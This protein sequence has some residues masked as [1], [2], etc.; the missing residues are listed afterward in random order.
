MT[1]AEGAAA[2]GAKLKV[3]GCPCPFRVAAEDAIT[4]DAAVL[5]VSRT[6]V[7]GAL[8]HEVCAIG[9]TPPPP[10]PPAVAVTS[11]TP[12]PA[13]LGGF[14]CSCCRM[15]MEASSERGPPSITPLPGEAP[16]ASAALTESEE[17]EEEEG[18]LTMGCR[19]CNREGRRER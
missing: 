2:A 6:E 12:S 16:D 5:G 9:R 8:P 4:V 17:E 3:R 14:R 19:G 18:P 11:G 10:P 1:A 7:V 15:P 13:G